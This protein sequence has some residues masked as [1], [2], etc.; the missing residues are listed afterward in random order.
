[1]TGNIELVQD[2]DWFK[3]KLIAGTT[4]I[5]ELTGSSAGGGTL[6]SPYLTLYDSSNYHSFVRSG[7]NGGTGGS[8]LFS[9]TPTI[10]GDYFLKANALSDASTG[11]YTLKASAAGA[12]IFANTSPTGSV[13]ISGTPVQNQILT[14]SNNLADADGLGSI[15]YTWLRDGTA[16]NAATQ[17][18][19]T[20][21]QADVGKKLSVQASYIDLNLQSGC[22]TFPL[23]D[24]C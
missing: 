2:S 22:V 14:A 19:Y 23:N 8:P 20:L 24:E 4:Y 13:T 10:S 7:Y 21:T 11:T 12:A 16:I 15:S 3:V 6:A 17:S 5:F 1:M 9:Y 18:T